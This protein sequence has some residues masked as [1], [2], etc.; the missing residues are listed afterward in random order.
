MEREDSAE[1]QTIRRQDLTQLA[2]LFAKA[3]DPIEDVTEHMQTATLRYEETLARIKAIRY[4]LIAT[5]FLVLLVL[6]AL[7]SFSVHAERMIEEQQRIV[8]I[9]M[10]NV[11]RVD[12]AIELLQSV[13]NTTRKAS[14]TLDEVKEQT[15]H[16]V[17]VVAE[18]DPTKAAVS[19]VKLVFEQDVV[20][21]EAEASLD[22]PTYGAGSSQTKRKSKLVEVPLYLDH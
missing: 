9:Q 10:K 3:I 16:S 17:K 2:D 5:C 21:E 7:F 19:P 13:E 4:L 8:T 14:T 22:L 18:T 20:E 15:H 11:K 12:R 6:A 1:D